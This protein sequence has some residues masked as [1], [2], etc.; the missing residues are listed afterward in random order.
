[1]VGRGTRVDRTQCSGGG[2]CRCNAASHDLSGLAEHTRP[3]RST[4]DRCDSFWRIDRCEPGSPGRVPCCRRLHRGGARPSGGRRTFPGL[5]AYLRTIPNYESHP[6]RSRSSA[7]NGM[8]GTVTSR[9]SS[10]KNKEP[11]DSEVSPGTPLTR[12]LASSP[13]SSPPDNG[14]EGYRRGLR[15]AAEPRSRPLRERRR[16]AAERVAGGIRGVL[17]IVGELLGIS[18]T[19]GGVT[20]F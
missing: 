11:D 19:A 3:R 15:K 20:G 16:A 8:F 1:M 12:N 9:S 2:V 5:R 18:Q 4:L 10:G 7:R 13:L 17:R 6:Y 14:A